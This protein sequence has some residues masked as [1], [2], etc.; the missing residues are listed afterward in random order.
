MLLKLLFYSYYS[1]VIASFLISFLLFKQPKTPVY[2]RLFS[3]FLG[4]TVCVE[5]YGLYLTYHELSNQV[6][7]SLFTMVEFIFYLY[8]LSCVVCNLKTRLAIRYILVSNA[9][10]ALAD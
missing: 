8:V 1:F 2:L 7:F 5:G 6:L 4:I 3:P 10:I 9:L